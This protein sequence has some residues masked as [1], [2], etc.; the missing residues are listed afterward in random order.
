MTVNKRDDNFMKE[1]MDIRRFFL[2]ILRR[3]WGILLIAVVGA[4]IGAMS[5]KIY[6]AIT[7][8]ETKYQK[9]TDYYIT[10]NLKDY[11]NGMD[12]YNAYTW[13]QF[14]LD[15]KIVDYALE[16][17]SGKVTKDEILSS[18]TI[19]MLSDYRVLTVVVTNTDKEKIDVINEAYKVSMPH[20]ADEINE[21]TKIELWSCNEITT[22]NVHNLTKNA[23]LA[24]LVLALIVASFVWAIYY[25]MD[26]RVYVEND[27]VKKNTQ[28]PFL[29]Y[30]CDKYKEDTD[31]NIKAIIK[32]ENVKMI[33][34]I[35]EASDCKEVIFQI[36]WG[37]KHFSAIEYDI[38][39]LNKQGIKVLGVVLTDCNS[40]YLKCYYGVK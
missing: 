35:K 37:N 10:F 30:D 19:Q 21:L 26:D 16:Q 1:S 17:T 27:W 4:I 15:D 33:K 11:P 3:W 29:G 28:I 5:Y 13:G 39:V 8:G 12:F 25:C 36:P 24:G 31:A 38:N 18:V 22:I 23:A 20:F 34:D 14:A 7:D 9:S 6:F 2:C 32:S 40:R